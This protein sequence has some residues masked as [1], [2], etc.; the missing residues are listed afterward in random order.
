MAE[1]KIDKKETPLIP[2]QP[3]GMRLFLGARWLVLYLML[4]LAAF[5][6]AV[7]FVWMVFGSF[8]SRQEAEEPGF[9]PGRWKEKHEQV[10]A[11]GATP[12]QEE[13]VQ[14]IE[15]TKVEADEQSGPLAEGVIS[16][17]AHQSE[18][19]NYLIVLRQIPD[20]YS[21]EFL[22]VDYIRW[23]FNS[24]FTSLAITFLQ[25]L[26]SAM[27]AYAFSRVQWPGRDQVFF[28]YLGTMM[29]PGVVLMIPNF[30]IMVW[31]KFYDSY[32]GLI[33][34]SAFT[35]F[36]TFLLRQFMMSIPPSLDEAARID[37]ASHW[38]TFWDVILPLSRSGMVALGIFTMLGAFQSFFWPLV[39]LKSQH[40]FTL[41]IGLLNLDTSYG[42]QTELI[43]AATVMSVIPLILLFIALQKQLIKGIQLGAVKG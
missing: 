23:Y 29:I 40:L 15:L 8:K 24:L 43:L 2:S 42:R 41:P 25:V 21:K 33:I 9:V 10:V 16:Q 11:A 13:A 37:G 17:Y 32:R 3:L 19:D 1:T 7:P 14:S 27:A 5:L 26:T 38:Q 39:M 35:A 30:Q 4:C 12:Q 18:W 31:M 22:E 36:G 6:T 34:P 20:K 28:L